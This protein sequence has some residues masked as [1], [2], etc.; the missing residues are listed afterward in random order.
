[1]KME[2]GVRK[3]TFVSRQV[4]LLRMAARMVEGW[5]TCGWVLL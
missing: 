3:E 5:L 1:M 2:E 4:E